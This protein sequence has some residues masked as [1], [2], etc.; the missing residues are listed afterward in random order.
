MSIFVADLQDM[1]KSGILD[2]KCV[3]EFLI[4][5]TATYL[6]YLFRKR[7]VKSCDCGTFLQDLLATSKIHVRKLL[8]YVL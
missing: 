6:E 3:A 2:T 5:E 7:W 4:R 1:F 8:K